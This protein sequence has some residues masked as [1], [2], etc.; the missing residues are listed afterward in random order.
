M[1][2]SSR[3]LALG[4]VTAA[5]MLSSVTGAGCS[6][7]QLRDNTQVIASIDAD[8]GVRMRAR[9]LHVLV[10]G[11]PYDT[12]GV[13]VFVVRDVTFDL[14]SYE[15]PIVVAL[16]PEGRDATRRYR[17]E[18]IALDASDAHV[19]TA[20]AISGYVAEQTLLLPVRLL[21]RCIGVTCDDPGQTCFG[22][23][24]CRDATVDPIPFDD[25]GVPGMDGGLPPDGGAECVDA[26]CD[27]G[28][29]CT[30]DF[31]GPG[32]A[33]VSMPRDAMC[34]DGE[35]CTTDAC[36]GTGAGD[37]CTH[38]PNTV[39]CDDGVYCNGIDVCAGGTCV[40]PGDP[41]SGM[42]TCSEAMGA[43]IGCAMRSDCPADDETL[44][45]CTYAEA[46][47][48]VAMQPRMTI[49]YDCVA[50]ICAESRVTDSVACGSRSTAG[51]SCGAT[52]C[53]GYGPCSGATECAL[54]GMQSRTCTDRVCG[55]GTCGTSARSETTT[56][57]RDTNGT[58]CEDG[59]PCTD[60]DMC[61]GGVCAPGIY[62][63]DAGDFDAGFDA[64]HDSGV[65]GSRDA[66][67]DADAGPPCVAM[68]SLCDDSDPCTTDTCGPGPGDA[69]GCSHVGMFPCGDGGGLP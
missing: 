43:C 33:C 58:L 63:C 24:D 14:S 18:A 54:V 47:A 12:N 10:Y 48:E 21:D 1:K 67:R 32:G 15:W 64:G 55:S 23:D 60:M 16:A 29:D 41:C 50:T 69:N 66:G 34:D 25:G 35:V 8:P 53:G 49:T 4:V 3:A 61:M 17:V 6:C 37:G 62:E 20:R 27:D 65:D 11:P 19:A 13:P 38:E 26:D 22:P 44:G 57:S 31:C 51:T 52:T 2:L 7:S 56:C 40:H 9:V 45:E 5:L 42:T 30:L 28:F 36:T 46:C 68:P 59:N 39:A